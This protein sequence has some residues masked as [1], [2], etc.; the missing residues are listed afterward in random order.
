MKG[1]VRVVEKLNSLFGFISGLCIACGAVLIMVEIACRITL[2]KSLL[3]TDEYTGYFM[4]VS[5]FMGLGYVEM[6][7]GHIRMDLIDLLKT[8]RPTLIAAL[9]AF[10]YIAAILFAAYMTFVCWKL[11]YQSL[12]Y[13]SKSTQISETPL[14]YPQFFLTLGAFALLLQY[15]CNL[16][17]FRGDTRKK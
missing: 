14:A 16:A 15:V 10:S 1:V 13:E 4:T 12:V 17:K 3:V 7:G 6:K 8:R 11:F 2:R 5:S 9:R